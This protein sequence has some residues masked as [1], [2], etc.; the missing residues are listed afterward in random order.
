MSSP[1]PKPGAIKGRGIQSNR[2]GRFESTQVEAF[3]DGWF[4]EHDGP[5]RPATEVRVETAKSIISENQSPDL[6][7]DLSLNPYRGCEHGLTMW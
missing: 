5:A 3:D 1:P 6:P 7:F 4:Q 2:E